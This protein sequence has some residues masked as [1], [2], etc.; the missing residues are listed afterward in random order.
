MSN[1]LIVDDDRVARTLMTKVLETAQYSCLT[2]AS[3]EEALDVLLSHQ[4]SVIVTDLRMPGM[5]GLELFQKAKEER[6]NIRGIL[7]SAYVSYD[8][9]TDIMESGLDDCLIKPVNGEALLSSVAR[10]LGIAK[11]W[12]TRVAELRKINSD[13][14][15]VR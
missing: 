2:A 10:S 7:C 1:I 6:S 14:M 3:A 15:E 4:V 5:D 8:V 12:K 9:I 13:N 11:H